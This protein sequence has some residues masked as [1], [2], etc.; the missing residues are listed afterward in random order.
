MRNFVFSLILVTASFLAVS[1]CDNGGGG[2]E[3][4]VITGDLKALIDDIIKC[5]MQEKLL[6][7]V[8]LSVFRNGNVIY[9]E[10]FGKSDVG[11]GTGVNADTSF[12]IGS[13]SKTFTALAMLQ[14]IENGEA[15]LDDPMALY[16]DQEVP[17]AWE[18]I[19]IRQLLSM[20]SGI[21]EYMICGG[22]PKMGEGC[23]NTPPFP[24]FNDCGEGFNCI[25]PPGQRP[26][27]ENLDGAKTLP[28]LF[29]PGEHYNYANLNF[30]LL[31]LIVENI[32]GV[33]FDTYLNNNVLDPLGMTST[34]PSTLPLTDTPNSSL[35]YRHV[36]EG[37]VEG[38]FECI[39]FDD[40]PT[41]C[42]TA[43]PDNIKCARIAEDDLTAPFQSFTAGY[44]TTTHNDMARLE[45]A[46][47]DLSPILLTLPTYEEMWTNQRLDNGDFEVFGLGWVVCSDLDDFLACPVAVDPLIGADPSN[48]EPFD[49]E[50]HKGRIVQKDGG[51]AGFATQI[52]RYLDEG[53]TVYVNIN[54]TN[55][56]PESI[57]FAPLQLAAEVA[58]TIRTNQ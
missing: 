57:A 43:P 10:G 32:S 34:A 55:K 8:E 44:L 17:P 47:H 28:L 3:D 29:T 19:T 48:P 24:I 13:V 14:L 11:A 50:G 25:A 30:V 9:R 2:S 21:P 26:F 1:G 58:D 35:A 40:P 15:E 45:K 52:V 23:S 39:V 56:E 22:G 6:P 42:N 36:T 18:A 31:G 54:V 5:T 33:S 20:S 7:G 37:E 51:V 12:P 27:M 38:E 53:L 4:E 49:F 41:G 16:L 46:Y